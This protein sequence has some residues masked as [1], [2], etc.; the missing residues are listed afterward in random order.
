[1]DLTNPTAYISG[2]ALLWAIVVTSALQSLSFH[3]ARSSPAFTSQHK[4]SSSAPTMAFPAPEARRAVFATLSS[5]AHTTLEEV[6]VI[7]PNVLEC[8][9]FLYQLAA[10][11]R[12]EQLRETDLQIGL[13]HYVNKILEIWCSL[14]ITSTLY[15]TTQSKLV[16]Q[17][18]LSSVIIKPKKI[19]QDEMLLFYVQDE[20]ISEKRR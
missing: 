19:L 7:N 5:G 10:L 18:L 12:L 9:Y 2:S 1:M 20:G 3:R 13:D 16:S 17:N 14:K 8:S 6:E 4:T 15:S 11:P